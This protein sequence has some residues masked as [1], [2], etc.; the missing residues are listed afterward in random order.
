MG[1]AQA[2]QGFSGGENL[3]LQGVK[4]S[5]MA[6]QGNVIWRTS[7]ATAWEW[8]ASVGLSYP[9]SVT[10]A[11]DT[12]GAVVLVAFGA[13]FT[14]ALNPND[15]MGNV[16]TQATVRRDGNVSLEIWYC[17]NPITSS[18][19][20]FGWGA[21]QYTVMG[22]AC[23][24][25]PATAAIDQTSV[26]GAGTSLIATLQNAPITPT[27]DNS[28]VLSGLAVNSSNPGT[29]SLDSGFTEAAVV[30]NVSPNDSVAGGYLIQAT[31]QTVAPTWT[32]PNAQQATAAMVS[33]KPS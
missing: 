33:F 20:T 24:A 29:M 15:S 3:A 1:F 27:A 2:G 16:W 25:G 7:T 17:L 21:N 4:P 13:M 23:F 19:H 14:G 31:A 30:G 26:T 10:A 12:T 9:A 5:G 11:I 6:A 32:W 28:L 8:L 18:S 22:V